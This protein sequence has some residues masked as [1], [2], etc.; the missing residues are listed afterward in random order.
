MS[1]WTFSSAV[2]DKAQVYLDE[3]RVERD[4]TPTVWWVRGTDPSRR[5]RVQTDADPT[6]M[7]ATWITCTCPHG[8]NVGAGAARCSHAVAVLLLIQAQG[9]GQL[10]PDAP[11]LSSST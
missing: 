2:I 6:T 9:R 10:W 3:G 4:S 8:L 5:Y 7:R 11:G 1:G